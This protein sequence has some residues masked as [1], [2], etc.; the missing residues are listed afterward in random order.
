M[1]VFHSETDAGL[2][3]SSSALAASLVSAFALV[4]ASVAPRA[5]AAELQPRSYAYLLSHA[6]VAAVGTVTGVSS[7][8][9]SEGRKAMIEVDGLYKGR[10]FAKEIEVHWNDK[11]FEETAF[12]NKGKVVV[13]LSMRKDTTY[14][15]I[16]PG[17]SGW[18]L[19]RVAI[20]G[21]PV[22]AVEYAYPMDLMTDVPASALRET[23]ELEKSMNFQVTKRKQWIL[24]D[25]L[26]PPLRPV[27]LPKPKAVAK[28]PAKPKAKS[29]KPVSKGTAKSP[30]AAPAKPK[31]GK[32]GSGKAGTQ[33]S[34]FIP[35]Q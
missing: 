27:V 29:A 33:K 19:E 13:F 12:K 9:L 1:P 34:W 3:A 15:L 10:I 28:S 17:I 26:L 32:A 31:S 6:H 16:A 21:K 14:A 25:Q 11:E 2:K 24:A 8:F 20:N 35:A 30:R 7:G 23:E 4:F 18:P 22:R 5:F